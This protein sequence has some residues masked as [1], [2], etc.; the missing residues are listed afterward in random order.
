MMY[1]RRLFKRREV[2]VHNGKRND[3]NSKNGRHDQVTVAFP[4]N[5]ILDK[6]DQD[7]LQ[8]IDRQPGEEIR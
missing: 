3:C 1:A 4:V 2:Q 7:G 5:Y 8:D 6:V